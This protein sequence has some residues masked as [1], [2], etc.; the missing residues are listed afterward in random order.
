MEGMIEVKELRRVLM[1]LKDIVEGKPDSFDN[2]WL[3]AIDCLF[4]TFTELK[5]DEEEN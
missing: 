5:E 3:A 2:G 1:D 4:E